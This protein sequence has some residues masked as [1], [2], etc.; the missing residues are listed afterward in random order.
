MKK[1]YIFMLPEHGNIGD[2]A[3]GY[4]EQLFL[5]DHFG[6]L[7]IEGITTP[8]WLENKED[9][10][11]NVQKEDVIFL[12][13]GGYIGNLWGESFL[14]ENIIEEFPDNYKIMFPNTLTYEE[15]SINEVIIRDAEWFKKQNRIYVCLREK[16]SYEMFRK[17]GVACGCFA[18]MALYMPQKRNK[19]TQSDNILL[20]LRSDR[21][22]LYDYS[23]KIRDD[24]GKQKML[25]EEFDLFRDQRIS[26][27]D[28]KVWLEKIVNMFQESKCVITDRLHGMIISTI[29]DVPCI[30][31]DNY[32][33]K[34]KYVYE[35]ER[36]VSDYVL[37]EEKYEDNF[38]KY[39]EMATEKKAKAGGYKRPD[40]IFEKMA[41]YIKK[42]IGSG[43]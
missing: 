10:K 22:K 12:N 25:I 38:L 40:Y 1:A 3:I 26:Q 31:I 16:H 21:E 13:G 24:L 17:F 41:D 19:K 20:C 9:I 30:A 27:D 15:T 43:G 34:I 29:C 6:G 5:K 37:M 11:K 4:A 18:D 42:I 33:H 23:S 35:N 7:V 2:Y 28:G 32:T 39:V 8:M 36:F 14:Y